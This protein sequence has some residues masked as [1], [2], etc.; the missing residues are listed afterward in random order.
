MKENMYALVEDFYAIVNRSNQLKHA[1]FSF[2]NVDSI[3]IAS[4]HLIEMIGNNS[5]M[6]TTEIAA[7]LGIT[8]GAVSQM[9]GKLCKKGLMEKQ[10]IKG[11]EKEVY[12]VLTPLGE[13]IFEEHEKLHKKMY[14]EME[15]LL[16][17]FS[18]KDMEKLHAFFQHIQTYMDEYSKELS[19]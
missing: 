13:E 8:K 18:E 3:N 15:L 7:K 12:L 1:Q 6:N 10:K 19:L 4:L 11:N 2:A 5:E 14:G 9:T 16:N 17:E